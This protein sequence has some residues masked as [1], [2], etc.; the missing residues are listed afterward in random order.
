MPMSERSGMD[1]EEMSSGGRVVTRV[2][3]LLI[4]STPLLLCV[5]LGVLWLLGGR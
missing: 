3:S 1:F 5:A 4:H 2:I